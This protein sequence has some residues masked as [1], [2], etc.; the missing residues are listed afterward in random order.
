[1]KLFDE[2]GN[3]VSHD[4]PHLIA[5]PPEVRL[6]HRQ[7]VHDAAP[8]SRFVR[9]LEQVVVV[10]ERTQP[11]FDNERGEAIGDLIELRR[12]VEEAEPFV[13]QLTKNRRDL[14]HQ[15]ERVGTVLHVTGTPGNRRRPRQRAAATR[16]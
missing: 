16:P 6:R 2:R 1:M 4:R 10:H 5:F 3:D 12:L 8:F 15:P 14:S 9:V 13:D 11:A 7:R